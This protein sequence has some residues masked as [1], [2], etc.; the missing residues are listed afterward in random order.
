MDVVMRHYSKAASE[1][2]SWAQLPVASFSQIRGVNSNF[3][4]GHTAV[5][6]LE[7]GLFHALNEIES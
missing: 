6:K 5:P 2:L 7:S 4:P 3:L 1:G